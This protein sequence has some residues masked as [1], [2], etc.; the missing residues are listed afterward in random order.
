M[1]N[2]ACP[3]ITILFL[4]ASMAYFVDTCSLMHPKANSFFHE[5]FIP[6]IK[7]YNKRINNTENYTG[8]YIIKNVQV[9]LDKFTER[10]ELI[11]LEFENSKDTKIFAR[12]LFI[13][14][15]SIQT[16][17]IVMNSLTKKKRFN[18]EGKSVLL[19][20]LRLFWKNF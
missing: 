10:D 18:F 13:G 15:G 9:E 8:I 1:N 5:T 12:K 17:R 16:P 6:K 2:A 7:H 14:T 11:E 4:R 20:S 19:Y 3:S